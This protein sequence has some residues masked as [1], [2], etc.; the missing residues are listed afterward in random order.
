MDKLKDLQEKLG[1]AWESYK[2]H[3]DSLGEDQTKWSE[4]DRTKF[5]K[6]DADVNKIEKDIDNLNERNER[7]ERDKAREERF[8]KPL[9]DNKDHVNGGE[10][11]QKSKDEQEEIRSNLYDSYLTGGMSALNHEDRGQFAGSD[12]AGGYLITPQKMLKQILKEVDDAVAI[13]GLATIHSLKKAAS[14]GVVKLDTDLDDWDWTQELKTGNLDDMT[15]GKREMRPHPMAKRVKISNT[16]IQ[17][18]D[19]GPQAI[20]QSRM[21]VKQGETMENAYMTGTGHNKPL[22]LFVASSDGI[23]TSRDYSTDATTTSM[24]GDQLI[25]VQG[26]LK[27]GYE[28][29]ARW[30]MH[31]DGITQIRKLKDGNGQYLWS[32]GLSDGVGRNILGK[33]YVVSEFA[34]NTFTT[35][36]YVGMYGDFKYYWILDVLMM[37]IQVLKELYAETNQIGYIGRYEGDGQ[38]VM[39]EAFVRIKL[40]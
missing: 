38:P 35:G 20:V 6:L 36:Q 5:N 15:F 4:E 23:S 30:L 25:G 29:N 10:N 12:I 17:M 1:R 19:M 16:L 37:Q 33:P 28:R 27:P 26:T 18:S 24:S 2:E 22:G 14:L 8:S 32:P 34:P 21:A 9:D 11:R 3:R 31:R 39:E 40:G 13:R 7:S